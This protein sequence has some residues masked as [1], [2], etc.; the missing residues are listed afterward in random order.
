MENVKIVIDTNVVL[1]FLLNDNE[2]QSEL[3]S[4]VISNINCIVPIEVITE[5]VFV[6]SKVY[7]YNRETICDEIKDFAK[8]RESIL[9]ESIQRLRRPAQCIDWPH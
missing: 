8:I 5:V 2:E 1:R 4:Q 6:L 7:F 3:A 9:L